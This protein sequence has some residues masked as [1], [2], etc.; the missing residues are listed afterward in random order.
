LPIATI[1]LSSISRINKIRYYHVDIARFA[2]HADHKWVDNLLSHHDIPGVEGA[3]QGLAR[4]ISETGIYHIVLIRLLS[5]EAGMSTAT[6]VSVAG[7]LLSSHRASVS[8]APDLE[9]ALDRD[10]FY[11]RVDEQIAEAVEAVTPARRGR[12]P[13]SA[14]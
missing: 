6:A 14:L 7:Q 11:S 8:L 3:R 9:I 5:R 12:P 4:R 10:A 2:A 1:Y 13:K